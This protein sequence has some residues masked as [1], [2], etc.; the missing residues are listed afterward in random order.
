MGRDEP[1]EKEEEDLKDLEWYAALSVREQ[2]TVLYE[3]IE[4][5]VI[6]L[7]EMIVAALGLPPF[8]F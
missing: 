3:E 4:C 5:A 2:N 8:D 6:P 7:L 1:K